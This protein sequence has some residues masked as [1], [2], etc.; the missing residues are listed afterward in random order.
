V[1]QGEIPPPHVQM[2]QMIS[3]FWLSRSVY[4]AA[5]LG[6]AD[7][8]R[9]RPR[10]VAELA[11]ATGTHAQSLYRLLRALACAGVFAEDEAGRFGTTPLA[12]TLERDAPGSMRA[13]AMTELGEEHYPAW[14]E[15]LH[16][17]RT[18]E[19][20]FDK[21]F[22]MPVFDFFARN[23]E[24]ARVFNDA[25]T[26]LTNVAGAAVVEAYDFKPFRRVVD[27]GG[28]HGGFLAAILRANPDAA[29]V[30]FDS[31]QVVEGG[32]ALLESQGFAGRCEIVGGD[33]FEEVAAGGDLYALKWIIHDWDDAQSAR[34]LR[35]VRR[36]MAGGGR[37]ILV[38]QVIPPG[39][40]PSLGK[41]VDLNM[42]VMTGGRER[43]EEE[44]RALYDAAGFR[45]T[46]VIHTASPMSIIE[47]EPA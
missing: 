39:N 34:I 16:S 2:L 11:E 41:F 5:K 24:N 10:T 12:A 1:S 8:V 47:G 25:M 3:G 15:L 7:L 42:L 43:T 45:L 23:P 31:P 29:G 46:R 44:F 17:I 40:N 28:G 38:E 32:R 35:N 27:V 14:G 20:A 4:A 36:A 19:T 26:G 37:L 18:G 6:L 22:G 9:E 30:L 21:V 33:F 13:F